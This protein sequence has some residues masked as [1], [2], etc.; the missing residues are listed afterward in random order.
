M[1][2]RWLFARKEEKQPEPIYLDEQVIM[3]I[4]GHQE[5]LPP[6]SVLLEVLRICLLITTN[7]QYHPLIADALT[8]ALLSIFRYIPHH[9]QINRQQLQTEYDRW[10]NNRDN[11]LHDRP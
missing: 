6:Y 8:N 10:N 4:F 1:I 2:F 11:Y 5:M 3:R 9:Y 7:H